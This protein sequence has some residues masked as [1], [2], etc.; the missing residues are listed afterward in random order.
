LAKYG[1]Y[2][3][4]YKDAFKMKADLEKQI[5]NVKFT[6]KQ[7]G[8]LFYIDELPVGE[9]PQYTYDGIGKQIDENLPIPNTYKEEYEARQKADRQSQQQ[10][11]HA[12]DAYDPSQSSQTA[13]ING[14]WKEVKDR[15][16]Y[17][18]KFTEA[19]GSFGQKVKQV[20]HNV[21][22][23]IQR[24][25]NQ[26]FNKYISPARPASN[27]FNSQG[28]ANAYLN[29]LKRAGFAD[30]YIEEKNVPTFDVYDL[31]GVK[32]GSFN[33]EPQAKAFQS[34][35]KKS[36]MATYTKVNDS[37]TYTVVRMS[38]NLGEK[39]EKNIAGA[40]ISKES[41]Q[42]FGQRTQQ[43]MVDDMN[44]TQAAKGRSEE[45]MTM[46]NMQNNQQQQQ[47][48]QAEFYSQPMF[49]HDVMGTTNQQ[50]QQ[51]VDD[52]KFVGYQ[53]GQQRMRDHM[54]NIIGT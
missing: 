48:R 13:D 9:Q 27:T 32:Q 50:N 10:Q 21:N 17:R 29:R 16:P 30:A 22:Q 49:E 51:P 33:N 39:L 25:P 35:L 37:K 19:M 1:D 26:L 3:S 5:P 44:R 45:F 52:G 40:K 4:D 2:F 38:K 42:R 54:K 6:V 18:S 31:N 36:E 15:R 41:M 34:E 43:N 8:R 20:P 12:G 46:P 24:P 23:E 11:P 53:E 7:K 28:E 14:Q 47:Q